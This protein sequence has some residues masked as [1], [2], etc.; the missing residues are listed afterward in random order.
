MTKRKHQTDRSL[1][2]AQELIHSI[3]KIMTQPLHLAYRPQTL[4]ALVGQPYVQTALTNA[5][6]YQQIAPAYLFNGSRGTGKTSTARIFAKSLNCLS[7]EAPTVTPCGTCQSCRSIEWSNSLDVTEI[8][9]ASHNGVD[10][11]RELAHMVNLAPVLGRYRIVILDKCHQLTTQ[12][13]NA[14]LKCI[15]EPPS[16]VVFILCTTEL[17]KVLP[18]IVSRC[19]RFEFRALATQVITSQLRQIADAEG[20]A[21]ADVA[22]KAIARL[23]EGGMRDALQLLAQASLLSGEVTAS[24]IIEL[25]GGVSEGD[26][27][28]LFD[29]LANHNTFKLL[30]ASRSL[31]DAG[32]APRL[33]LSTLLQSYRDLLILKAAPGKADLLTSPINRGHLRSL[34]DQWSDETLQAGL[35]HLQTAENQLRYTANAQVWLEVC[36]LNLMPQRMPLSKGTSQAVSSHGKQTN[37][38]GTSNLKEVWERVLVTAQPN[39]RRLLEK[40]TLVTL[41]ENQAVVRVSPTDVS[42]FEAHADKISKLLQKAMRS[43]QPI[44]LSFKAMTVVQ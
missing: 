42:K 17:H 18:T 6:A 44:T 34:A 33:I 24:Q 5:I 28:N 32:K 20:I 29:A 10:E 40:A 3:Q 2:D 22:L 11:A 37:G 9:A 41:K 8:D 21:I 38:N 19:Q 12:S 15:E 36:L 39:A 35:A 23:C 14:L 13:Q 30:Q 1:G 4:A 26:L 25:A 43:N 31:L 16:H 27:L 7:D